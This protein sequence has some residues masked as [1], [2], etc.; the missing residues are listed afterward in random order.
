MKKSRLHQKD[1]K[2]NPQATGRLR[3]GNKKGGVCTPPS[4]RS[5]KPNLLQFDL[6]AGSFDQFFLSFFGFFLAQRLP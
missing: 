3:A 1:T 6:G 2:G 4:K 5:E